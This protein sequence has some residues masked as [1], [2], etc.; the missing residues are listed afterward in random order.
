[1]T[2]F[3]IFAS[4]VLSL[5]LIF[6]IIK[7]FVREFFSLLAYV[8][9]YLIAVE[10][11]GTFA[12]VLMVS[13]PSKPIA[14]LIA[15]VTIYIVTAIVISLIGKIVKSILWSGTD[16][17]IFDRILGGILGLVKGIAILVAVTFPLH[18]FPEVAKKVTENSYAAP[19]L[20][21]VLIFANQNRGNLSLKK[22]FLSFDMNEAKEKFNE[23]KDLN[24]LKKT[25]DDLKGKLPGSDKPL[26]QYSSDDRKKLEDILKSV[27]KN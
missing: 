1:M 25:Y 10:Y 7:G 11:Q 24:K 4:V 14:K 15:F 23:M 18:F 27:D 19:Y 8:G 13:I 17:S 3:D 21:D 9:G 22:T 2:P 26:D 16:L 5:T 12:Q 20:A 6:S